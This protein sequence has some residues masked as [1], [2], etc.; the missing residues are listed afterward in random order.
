MLIA[1]LTTFRYNGNEINDKLA[2]SEADILRDA[3][4]DKVY[5]HDEVVR[6]IST[7]SKAQLSATFNCHKEKQGAFISEVYKIKACVSYTKLFI[8]N[9]Y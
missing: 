3:I 7:R 8:S 9:I 6:I 2:S 5:N 1:L 4:K